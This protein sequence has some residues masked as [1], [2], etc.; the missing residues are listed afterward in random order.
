MTQQT[1]GVLALQGG[2]AEHLSAL[3]ALGCPALRVKTVADLQVCQGLIMPGGESTTLS[4]LWQSGVDLA[5]KQAI[6]QRVKAGDLAVW[7]TCAG[8][9]LL[10]EQVQSEDGAAD[11][12]GLGLMA[13]TMA[14]NAY[15]RQADSF[16]APVSGVA[17]AEGEPMSG[18]FIRAPQVVAWSAP[19]QPVAWLAEDTVVGLQQDRCLLTTFHPELTQDRRWHAYFLSS[20]ARANRPSTAALI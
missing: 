10:A 4:C 11:V 12:A 14:R 9:I 19:C 1:V 16:V 20:S 18:V 6:I 8:A 17:D 2:V 3:Q 15:G 13:V 5:L 7:G